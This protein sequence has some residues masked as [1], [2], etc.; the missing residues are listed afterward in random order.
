[1][2]APGPGTFRSLA[3]A[4]ESVVDGILADPPAVHEM[5]ADGASPLGV[6]STERECYLLLAELGAGARTLE[7]GLGISTAV[8]A[9]VGAHHTCITPGSAE[10]ERLREYC[11]RRGID[12]GRVRFE[13]DFSDV[14]LPALGNDVELDLVLIDGG[15]GFPVPAI[16]W[17]YAASKLVTGGTVILDDIHLPAVLQ[18]C[19]YLDADPAWTAGPRSGK[20]A[21]YQRVRGGPMRQDHYEQSFLRP[22]PTGKAARA[23]RAV[24]RAGDLYRSTR[25]ALAR[26]RPRR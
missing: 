18:L 5:S 24:T 8:L 22:P 3:T 16:D 19:Q 17:F 9:A 15:H 20:W 26:A 10:V 14:V 11:D 12:T 21:A 7:T 23:A 2:S 13:V 4:P 6:W 25:A 1:M